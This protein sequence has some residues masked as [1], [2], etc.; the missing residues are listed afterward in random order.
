MKKVVFTGDRLFLKFKEFSYFEKRAS[1]ANLRIAYVQSE[2]DNDL[3]REVKDASA[4]VLIA[5]NINSSIIDSMEKCE[6]ILTLSVGYDCVDLSAATGKKIP[7]CNTPAY[8][9][10]DVAN[11]AMTLVLSLARKLEVIIPHTR[12]ASWEYSYTKPIFN[13]RD[14]IFAI[15]GLGKIGRTIVPKVQGFG[16]RVIGY[17]PYID[18]DIFML[19]GVERK[20]ELDDLLREADYITIHTPLTAET[21]HMIDKQ[22]FN[23]MKSNA[24]IVNTARGA[25]IDQDALYEALSQKKISGAGIDVLEKEPPAEDNPLL[26]LDN[27]II[28][29]HIAWYSEESFQKDMGQGMDELVRVLSGHRPRHIVNP[30]IFDAV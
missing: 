18:D 12:N 4:I 14:K 1:E 24:V 16:M 17:D 6:L 29:P 10:D 13:F 15:I 5:R 20:Y 19:T 30:E 21:R 11:H 25:I 2:D 27:I 8:C 9:T 23:S 26:S 3:I 7:V 22:A 28:T